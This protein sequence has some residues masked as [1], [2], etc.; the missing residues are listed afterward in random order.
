VSHINI[1]K[2]ITSD[3]IVVVACLLLLSVTTTSC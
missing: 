2:N 1:V 3:H